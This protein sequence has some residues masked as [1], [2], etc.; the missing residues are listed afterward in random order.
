MLV[1]VKDDGEVAIA[2]SYEGGGSSDWSSCLLKGSCCTSGPCTWVSAILDSVSFLDSKNI[3]TSIYG[4]T[5]TLIIN[6]LQH[7]TKRNTISCPSY[8]L[9]WLFHIFVLTA[10]IPTDTTLT[11]MFFIYMSHIYKFY[12]R[13]YFILH[14]RI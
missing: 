12:R 2:S 1:G 4:F 8:V 13:A 5:R 11:N 7:F 3:Q 6:Y 14:I 9:P 10:L